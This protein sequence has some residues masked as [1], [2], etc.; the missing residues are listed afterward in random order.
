MPE[1]ISKLQHKTYEKG[2]FSDEQVRNLDETIELIKSF[3]WDTERTLTDVQLTG[4]SITIRDEDINYLKVGLYFN[5]KYCLYYLDRDNHLYEYHAPDIT[6]ACKIVTDFFAGQLDL[7]NFEKHFF[8]IGNQAHF[9]TNYFEYREKVWRILL[10]N[11]LTLIYGIFFICISTGLIKSN[12]PT[13]LSFMIILFA[14]LFLFLLGR[15]FYN[16]IINRN[17]YL[18]ISRGN[19]LFKFGYNEKNIQTYSKK[20]IDKVVI[21][22]SRGNRNPNLVCMYEIYFKDGNVIKFSNMLISD[23]ALK[24]KFPDFTITYGKKS[25]LKML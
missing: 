25:I 23:M 4:P 24:S 19:D 12:Q 2:E 21:Y 1:F 18:Q 15:I 10:L 13:G 17:N 22:E 16:A 6:D 11:I 14:G 9:V 3:P 5:G 7:E 8:N 20:D